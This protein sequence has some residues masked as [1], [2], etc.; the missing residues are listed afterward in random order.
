MNLIKSFLF[1]SLIPSFSSFFACHKIHLVSTYCRHGFYALI[2]NH[3]T[4]FTVEISHARSVRLL[5]IQCVY[6]PFSRPGHLLLLIKQL[7]SFPTLT[8]LYRILSNPRTTPLELDAL[9]LFSL[10][11]LFT[12]RTL[13]EL[14]TERNHQLLALPCSK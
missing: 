3:V 12:L 13:L 1:S 4:N 9:L 7:I 5:E 6:S 11:L 10:P 8:S 14:L 2:C